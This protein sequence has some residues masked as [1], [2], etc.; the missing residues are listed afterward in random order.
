MTGSA[1]TRQ[2]NR[3]GEGE[4]LRVEILDAARRLLADHPVEAL[5]QRAV[6]RE[7]GISPPALYLHFADRRA[8][9]WAVLE[10]LFAELAR[11][12]ETAAAAAKDGSPLRAWCLA[13]CRY[14]LE[15]PGHYRLL[16]E[17]W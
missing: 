8:L 10:Q 4:R 3:R 14:G 12:T 16:F 9:V 6:A 15:N 5:S 13:Y 2:R 17:S 7:V 11:Y 1:P